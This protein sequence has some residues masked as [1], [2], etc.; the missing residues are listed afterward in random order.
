MGHP[1]LSGDT[2]RDGNGLVHAD[3]RWRRNWTVDQ[4]EQTIFATTCGKD[5]DDTHYVLVDAPITCLTCRAAV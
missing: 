4:G 5:F 2:A 1:I 3:R